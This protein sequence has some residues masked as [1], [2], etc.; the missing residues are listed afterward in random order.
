[1]FPALKHTEEC[2]GAPVC[3]LIHGRTFR[4]EYIC[5]LH[6]CMGTYA[7]E[8]R[9]EHGSVKMHVCFCVDTSIGIHGK[10]Y[11]CVF[12]WVCVSMEVYVYI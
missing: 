4:P 3:V 8:R 10:V 9:G 7:K 11:M 2:L 6:V 12:I 5:V 1:M